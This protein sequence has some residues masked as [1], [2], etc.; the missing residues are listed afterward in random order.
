MFDFERLDVYQKIR[1]LNQQLL[2]LI[3][4]I[5]KE[6]PYLADQLKR[7]SLSA[8]LNLSEGTGRMTTPDKKQFYIR[9]RSSVFECVSVLHLLIDSRIIDQESY[10]KLYDQYEQVS[11]MMLG[12]IRGLND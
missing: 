9:S 5:Q 7:A 3:F 2:P 6:Y 11:K 10:D 8:M 4:S 1:G 12:M